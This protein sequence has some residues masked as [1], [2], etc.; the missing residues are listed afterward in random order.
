MFLN[1]KKKKNIRWSYHVIFIRITFGYYLSHLSAIGL[2]FVQI[3]FMNDLLDDQF[4]AQGFTIF[5]TFLESPVTRS[6]SL[7]LLFPYT[8]KVNPIN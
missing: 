7:S 3:Y 8:I 6:D 2:V 4:W 1:H 5:E